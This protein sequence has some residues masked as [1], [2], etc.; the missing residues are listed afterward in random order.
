M[1]IAAQ[2]GAIDLEALREKYRVERDKRLSAHPEGSSQYVETAGRF[3]HMADDPNAPPRP[4]RA[5]L[6]DAVEI[7]LT[8]AGWSNLVLGGHLRMQGFED[9]RYFDKAGDF[10]GAWYWNRYPGAQCD[11]EAYLYMPFLE[12]TGY[13]PKLRYAYQPELY[14]H[15]RRI[16]THFDLYR[17]AHFGTQVTELRW[18]EE[19]AL[20]LVKTDQSDAMKA[21]YVVTAAGPLSK[22]KLP[23][24]PG[25][26]T[27]RG[28]IFHTSRWDYGYTGG[29][30]E[31]GLTKL[32]DKRVA[33]VGTGATG[34]QVVPH[35]A[36]DARQLYVVQR[37]PSS[38]SERNNAPTDPAWVAS[39]TP[40]WWERRNENFS[41][42]VAGEILEE[43]MVSD[44]WTDMA[45]TIK[46]ML[47]TALSGGISELER[48]A[49]WERAD[50]VKMN[51]VRA[52]VDS[53]VN[54]PAT[55][56]ALKPW[57]RLWC[58]RPSF[59]DEYLQAFNRPN[60]ELVDTQ[61][62]G[63][64]RITQTGFVANGR[65]FDVDCIIFAT[66]FETSTAY[67]RR[68]RYEVFGRDGL[69][70]TDYWA[71]GVR[72]L[73]GYASHNFPNLFHVGLG[74]N[75]WTANYSC[76][77]HEQSKHLAF[78]IAYARD[79]GL[80][81]VEPTAEAEEG[82]VRE[83]A[84]NALHD[85]QFYIDCTPGYFNN[86]GH[87]N[88]HGS[89]LEVQYGKGPFE[90]FRLIRESREAGLPELAR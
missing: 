10:G 30:T 23:G 43:D 78:V 77:L 8:G 56:E 31:G 72:T 12:E 35:L 2:A 65:E 37:T 11:V 17:D 20:W 73:H 33:I 70:L 50:A 88:E 6:I 48:E 79:H 36:R 90:F 82:W 19:E 84:A 71:D 40:G 69:K 86:E 85:S 29:S 16:A 32:A 63:V 46:Q 57:Y 66:G 5:P 13:I 21:R 28:H 60:V 62:K 76:T 68:A 52:R 26:E 75:G 1:T 80:P 83:I 59:H 58:K 89:I 54:D 25:M 38:I 24:I 61:G 74:Q 18:I 51:A 15:A 67:T 41:R 64:E 7:L 22:P 49:I 47:P 44:C 87:V 42:I 4:A 34:I 55:A 81:F 27:F 3:A 14:E 45:K 9:I 53:L 39:L